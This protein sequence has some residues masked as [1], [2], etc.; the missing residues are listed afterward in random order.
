MYEHV[1]MLFALFRCIRN[2]LAPSE[3]FLRTRVRSVS[4]LRSTKRLT[5]PP[6]V[7]PLSASH[8]NADV[9]LSIPVCS[10]AVREYR[11]TPRIASQGFSMF[12]APHGAVER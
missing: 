5:P 12:S 1:P 7:K 8:V 3:A 9:A 2:R 6:R 11:K 4:P 10:E